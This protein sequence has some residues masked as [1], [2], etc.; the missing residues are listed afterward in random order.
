M[1][2]KGIVIKDCDQVGVGNVADLS[3]P[4]TNEKGK[5]LIMYDDKKWS[6]LLMS[7][8]LRL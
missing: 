2:Q 5:A 4:K 8:I 7:L 3:L 6:R 1:V